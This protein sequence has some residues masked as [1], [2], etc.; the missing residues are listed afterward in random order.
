MYEIIDDNKNFNA[1]SLFQPLVE[2]SGYNQMISRV[3][4]ATNMAV[5]TL[6]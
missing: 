4:K 5:E 6:I 1:L 2:A 3:L